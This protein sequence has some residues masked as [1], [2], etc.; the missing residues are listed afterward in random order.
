MGCITDEAKV[1]SLMEKHR[2]DTVM[3]FAAQTHVD[4]SFTKPVEF[5]EAN[6][7]GTA[8]LLKV[9]KEVGVRRFLH[10][11]TDEVYG[12]NVNN[13]VFTEDAHFKP[14]NPYSASKAGAECLVHG[15]HESFGNALPL[16]VV[17]PNNIYGPRQY[18]EKMIPKF[19][20]R[21]GRKQTLPLHGGGYTRRSFLFV[22]DAARAFDL[23]LRKGVPGMAYNIGAAQDSTRS[24]VEV[25]NALLPYFG[26]SPEQAK[27]HLEIVEDRAK[28]DASYDVDSTRI[29]ALGWSPKVG[30]A[31][32][33]KR[34]VEWYLQNPNHWGSVDHALLPHNGG[35]PA[36]GK[37]EKPKD[38][39]GPKTMSRL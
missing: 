2:V 16:V 22:E 6:V 21:L 27:N 35:L 23:V 36:G 31:E 4:R 14:G 5:S 28:N 34:T 1:K 12:E 33:L 37:P 13:V 11:S 17:R 19:I 24:V 25:A 30:F 15:Y 7:I 9:A 32:G 39:A 29:R 26:I 20:Y 10:V 8:V 38:Q 18:P 3:H